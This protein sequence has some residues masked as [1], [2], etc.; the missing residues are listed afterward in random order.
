M[1][2]GFCLDR[3]ALVEGKSL[4]GLHQSF[5]PR[6]L[7]SLSPARARREAH[8]IIAGRRQRATAHYDMVRDRVKFELLDAIRK[9]QGGKVRFSQLRYRAEAAIKDAMDEL[10]DVGLW[11]GVSGEQKPP[12][13]DE[14]RWLVSAK[15]QELG[16]LRRF[17]DE[18]RR[19]KV[20]GTVERRVEMYT[21]TLYSMMMAARVVSTAPNTVIRW[22]D[23]HDARECASCKYLARNSPYTKYS[24]PT[25]PRAGDTLCLS[26]C[27][28][29]LDLREVT[30]SEFEAVQ[31]RQRD[32]SYHKRQLDSIKRRR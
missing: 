7:A 9:F 6:D 27:R 16:Y 25:Q 14:K 32:K 19:G 12:T 3:T 13:Q 26:N 29:V 18:I 2:R 11:S 10:F 28:C 31:R 1:V 30:S 15:Q 24:L 5:S 8:R 17:L 22:E 20:K 23:K 21:D 4:S